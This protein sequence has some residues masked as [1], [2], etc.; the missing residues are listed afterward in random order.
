M[1]IG[2]DKIKHIYETKENGNQ[3][4]IGN[5]LTTD[6]RVAEIMSKSG[7]T[8]P[9]THNPFHNGQAIEGHPKSFRVVI[10]QKNR[11]DD[12]KTQVLALKR[13]EAAQK[14]FLQD[15]DDFT[16]YEMGGYFKVIEKFEDDEITM[17]GRG[18]KH[19][20]DNEKN[21]CQGSA[22]KLMMTF[23]GVPK[24]S[25][26]YY[27]KNGDG[28]SFSG[29]DFDESKDPQPKLIPSIKGRWIGIKTC[30]YNIPNGNVKLEIW[31]DESM[32]QDGSD[33]S[34]VWVPVYKMIDSGQMKGSK[35]PSFP[36]NICG[37]PN[38]FQIFTWGGPQV[39]F[40]IDNIKSM[41]FQKL[42][43]REIIPP[44]A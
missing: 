16:N 3:W 38:K 34:N 1:T 44:I 24:M 43:V 2:P 20:D 35:D 33:P 39:T 6:H 12:P 11:Y 23:H 18:G 37:A 28:Y 10:S 25:K 41:D 14:G 40:R 29:I 5:D 19:N 27:H 9:S 15:K 21:M 32:P 22:Y 8:K 36:V 31:V 7:Y 17:Y 30:V 42:S 13:K 26:E 4:Y